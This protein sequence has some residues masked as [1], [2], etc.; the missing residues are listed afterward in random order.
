MN[1]QAS[2]LFNIISSSISDNFLALQDASAQHSYYQQLICSLLSR[3]IYA[4]EGFQSL[5]RQLADIA[6]HAYFLRQIET[7]NL[8]SQIMLVLPISSELKGI[9]YYY[10]AICAKRK[11][12]FDSARGLLERVV[13]E[14]SQ[15]YKAR[16]FLTIGATYFDSGKVEAA[17][18][19]YL[20]AARASRECD[21]LTMAESQRQIA[22]I[23]S[24]HGDHKRALEGIEN[25]LPLIRVIAKHYPVLRYDYLNSLAVELGEVGRIDEAKAACAIALASPFST[26]YPN[27]S[28]TRDELE[29][30]RTRA[31]PSV[32][33]ISAALECTPSPNVRP[34]RNRKP[35]LALVRSARKKN[36]LQRT[37]TT[38]VAT[39]TIAR[40]ELTRSILSRVRHS[41]NPRGPPTHF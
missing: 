34:A 20:T 11:G 19:F 18:P 3:S 30:K 29:A 5:G 25:L 1:R 38:I 35:A 24:A 15:Q 23:Y 12:D 8:A 31:T 4:T 10:Q 27:W 41:I 33:A 26:A 32:V 37:I 7:V 9:A 17:L 14:A 6:Q 36:F 16:A 13:R 21:P 39:A 22:I 2:I 28:E 40:I